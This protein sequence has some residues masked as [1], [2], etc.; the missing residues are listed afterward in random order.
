MGYIPINDD[1]LFDRWLKEL[2]PAVYQKYKKN[3]DDLAFLIQSMQK[4]TQ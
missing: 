2:T 1:L 3:L 4:A